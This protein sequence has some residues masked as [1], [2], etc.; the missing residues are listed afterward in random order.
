MPIYEYI[1]AQC[2]KKF[3]VLRSMSDTSAAVCPKCGSS[4]TKRKMST[5][6]STYEG[7]VPTPPQWRQS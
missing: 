5:F 2:H 7:K 6:T 4:D 3:E 1:C